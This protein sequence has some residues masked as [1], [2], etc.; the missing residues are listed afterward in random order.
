[1]VTAR[2]ALA[3]LDLRLIGQ[4]GADGEAG[5]R[6]GG[7]GAGEPVALAAPLGRLLR[8][9]LQRGR[10]GLGPGARDHR[11]GRRPAR[12]LRGRRCRAADQHCSGRVRERGL[13]A[14]QLARGV[15]FGA[16]ALDDGKRV[17]WELHPRSQR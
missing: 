11:Y 2:A 15:L 7:E 5:A 9:L 4:H 12:Q 14:N 10:D 16:P 6:R 3:R 8:L 13:A 17:G 1:M